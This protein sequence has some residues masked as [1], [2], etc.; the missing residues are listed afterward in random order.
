[1]S[2]LYNI[3]YASAATNDEQSTNSDVSTLQINLDQLY[4]GNIS[5]RLQ[6]SADEDS[7]TFSVKAGKSYYIAHTY[8]GNLIGWK[9][10]SGQPTTS[11]FYNYSTKINVSNSSGVIVTKSILYIAKKKG[12]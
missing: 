5:S 2:K 8:D 11:Y 3:T 10:Q 7:Y 6:G 4:Q 9:A 12:I 1:M